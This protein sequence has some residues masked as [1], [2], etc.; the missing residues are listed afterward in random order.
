MTSMFGP[1]YCQIEYHGVIGRNRQK[2]RLAEIVKYYQVALIIIEV[3]LK[4]V[5][6]LVHN[7]VFTYT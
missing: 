5:V 1:Y 4:S 6:A 2:Q 3:I 7:K